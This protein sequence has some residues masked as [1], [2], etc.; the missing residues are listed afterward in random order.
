[1]KSTTM[2]ELSSLRLALTGNRLD[3]LAVAADLNG[4]SVVPS[5]VQMRGDVKGQILARDPVY[6]ENAS[7]RFTV[8][9]RG[10]DPVDGGNVVGRLGGDAG[11]ALEVRGDGG[12]GW[13][14]KWEKWDDEGG[15]SG[16][17]KWVG[18]VGGPVG[19]GRRRKEDQG[20]VGGPVGSGGM[21]KW[22]QRDDEGGGSKRRRRK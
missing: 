9:S 7:Q 6:F 1:M 22:E 3:L 21:K 10:Q 16:R 19:S 17:R 12:A 13:R 15:G 5:V 11:I 2:G 20:E 4:L 18:E 8:E 14:K